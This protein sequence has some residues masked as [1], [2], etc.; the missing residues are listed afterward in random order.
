LTLNLDFDGANGS[1]TLRDGTSTWTA[2]QVAGTRYLNT[3]AGFW[4][5][6][7]LPALASRYAGKWIDFPARD[8]SLGG[9]LA[10]VI[11]SALGWV[12]RAQMSRMLLGPVQPTGKVVAKTVY[13]VKCL[14]IVSSTGSMLD[15]ARTDARPIRFADGGH[16]TGSVRFRYP[17]GLPAA[18]VAPPKT[19]VVSNA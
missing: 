14:R 3:A 15:V 2:R 10:T 17:S 7:G 1:G 6:L 16:D 18:L 12:D 13:G 5:E 8:N 9:S 4:I 11:S 19:E